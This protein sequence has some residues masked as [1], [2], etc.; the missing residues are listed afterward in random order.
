MNLVV[1]ARDAMPKGGKLTIETD[2][3]FLDEDCIKN[4]AELNEPGQYIMLAVS[5]S[6]CGMDAETQKRVFEP[7]F[8]TKSRDRGTGLG[9]A[10]VYG[11]VKQHQ[12]NVWLYSE[13]DKGTTFKIFFPKFIDKGQT[14]ETP[15][16]HAVSLNGSETVLVVEDD[17]MVRGFISETLQAHGY[18]IIEAEGP[19]EALKLSS[20]YNGTIQLLLTDVIMPEMNGRELYEKLSLMRPQTK[21]IFVSG[22]T[23]DVIVHHNILEEGVNFIQKPFMISTLTQKIRKVLD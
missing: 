12:G 9:L 19:E 16:S 1:N 3:A 10:T 2:N 17:K 14:P 15:T 5:D 13:P 8:T 22:Y 7:F 18:T 4:H 23:D 6:G 20:N 21:V 11:I